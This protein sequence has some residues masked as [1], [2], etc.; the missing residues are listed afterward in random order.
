MKENIQKELA[1][2]QGVTATYVAGQLTVKGPKGEVSRSLSYPTIVLAVEDG[3]VVLSSP[4][5]TKREK[6]MIGTFE[7]HIKNMIKGVQEMFEYKLKICSGHFPMNVAVSGNKLTVKNFLGEK[8]PRNLS[9][10]AQAKVKVNGT[11][12]SVS[13]CSKELAGQVSASIEQL[14]RITNKDVR[15]FQ[16]GIWITHKAK[17]ERT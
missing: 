8:H 13:A 6:R 1:L 15:I 17:T 12:I 14:C 11:E 7:S 3:K 10:D 4:K 5:A 2:P 9:F 16:D